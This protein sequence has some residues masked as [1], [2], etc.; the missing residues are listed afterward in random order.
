MGFAKQQ[1][2]ETRAMAGCLSLF[3]QSERCCSDASDREHIALRCMTFNVITRK[4]HI[5]ASE[6]AMTFKFKTVSCLV[7]TAVILLGTSTSIAANRK[8][9]P[10]RSAGPTEL[11]MQVLL[12]RASFSP[13]EMDGTGG[14]NSRQAL[15]AF[16]TAR[17]LSP[18]P[19]GRKALLEALGAGAFES[20]V[21]YTITA[22]DVAGPF[23]ET[24]PQGMTEMAK[25]PGLYYTSVLQELGERFH[26]SPAL[27]KHLNV[28][29]H[30]I[31][32]ENIRVPNVLAAEQPAP[33]VPPA[34][35]R[36]SQSAPVKIVVS[37]KASVLM[38][39]DRE[40][41]V[42][43]FAPVTSGSEH[44]PLPFGNWVITSVVRNPIYNYNPD[45][46]WNADPADAKEKIA[47]GPNNPVGIVWMGLNAP[48]YGIHGTAEPELIGHSSSH[49]CVR[50]TNWDAT[51]VAD[52]VKDGTPV[53]FEE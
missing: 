50:M 12:D 37:K 44:D 26:S 22:E 28:H 18:G 5:G 47:A 51:R 30:F 45:R 29:A 25:L 35:S 16:E 4:S 36:N 9:P 23:T 33:Q 17:G 11:E 7:A 14:K 2:F 13:G 6:S 3:S 24:I 53:V 32:G 39:Y 38:V 46:F 42:I 15:A 52:L 10:A 34:T 49:G 8:A 31:E 21:S 20:I 1:Q 41:E 48:H 27:L 40:G 19:R 43:F